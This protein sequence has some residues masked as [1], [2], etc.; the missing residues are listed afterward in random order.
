MPDETPE[1]KREFLGVWISAELWTDETL[2]PVEK[3]LIAEIE[4]L[5][6]TKAVCRAGNTYLGKMLGGIKAKTVAN[7]L[8]KLRKSNSVRETYQGSQRLLWTVPG[9]REPSRITGMDVPGIREDL[10]PENGNIDTNRDNEGDK[11]L[12]R[13]FPF[14]EHVDSNLCE[15]LLTNVDF[16]QAWR[17]FVSNRS[18]MGK[19]LTRRSAVAIL[20][21]LAK[22]P[23]E[24]ASALKYVVEKTSW[25]G[26]EWAWIDREYKKNAGGGILKNTNGKL[27]PK[28]FDIRKRPIL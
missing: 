18:E 12:A 13:Q 3:F 11:A 6:G 19:K 2:T 23:S 17:D 27:P 20:N 10:F 9:K 4:S 1:L 21:E 8:S 7:M 24:T 25:R 26:F 5:G 14:M 15:A 28:T 22:R 16:P